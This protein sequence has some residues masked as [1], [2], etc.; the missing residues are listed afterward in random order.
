MPPCCSGIA[1]SAEWRV[2]LQVPGDGSQ[3]RPASGPVERWPPREQTH[4]DP[5][6]AGRAGRLP[7]SS[8]PTPRAVTRACTEQGSPEVGQVARNVTT[9]QCQSWESAMSV[10]SKPTVSHCHPLVPV[11]IPKVPKWE[12][13]SK[14]K[15]EWE[16]G[17]GGGGEAGVPS[18]SRNHMAQPSPT[19][20][21]GSEDQG[22]SQRPG[23]VLLP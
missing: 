12:R 9:D 13:M 7:E 21:P 11:R 1:W 19:A 3:S 4:R 20:S 2:S 5:G 10:P 18:L 6:L 23:F 16:S 8:R 22:P 17:A 14:G 15:D